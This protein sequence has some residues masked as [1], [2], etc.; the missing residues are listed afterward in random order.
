MVEVCPVDQGRV[1]ARITRINAFFTLLLAVSYIITSDVWLMVVLAADFVLRIM[2]EGRLSPLTHVSRA[3]VALLNLDQQMINS[4]PKRFA[5]KI[6]LLFAAGIG[7]LHFFGSLELSLVFAGI[8][9]FFALLE[10]VFEFCVA[11]KIYTLLY[12]IWKRS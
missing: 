4:A 8:L 1:N 12:S 2:L 10:F 3:V 7:V 6:G 9:S 5:A 11:C